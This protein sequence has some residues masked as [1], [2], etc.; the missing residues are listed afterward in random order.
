MKKILAGLVFLSSVNSFAGE[1]F[2][3]TVKENLVY[4]YPNFEEQQ[5]Q[6]WERAFAVCAQDMGKKP[7][8]KSAFVTKASY[9]YAVVS[10][11][12]ECSYRSIR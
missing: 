2:T 4:G 1:V 8:L 6:L 3:L 9:P 12:F 11:Q 5:S 10:A 7:T